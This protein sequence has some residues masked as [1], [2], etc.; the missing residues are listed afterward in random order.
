MA[1]AQSRMTNIVIEAEGLSKRYRLGER[2]RYVALR[3][4]LTESLKAPWRW[5]RSG[6]KGPGADDN[7]IWSLK[8]V[9]FQVRDGEA[10]G[11]VGRNGAGKTTLLKLLARV[12]RPTRGRAA[13]RGRIGSLLEVGT[14]FHPELTGRENVF[15]NGAILGMSRAEIHGKFDEI[16]EFSGVARFLD[17]PLKHY[18]SGMQ[19]RLAFSVA[20]HLEPE[21]LLVDEVLAVGDL[22]FQKKC[23]GKMEEV[24]RHGRTV[25]FVSHSM[26]AI[27]R[28]CTRAIW[29]DGGRVRMMG[30]ADECVDAYGASVEALSEPGAA[31]FAMRGRTD[32][33]GSQ[34]VRFTC[35][36]ICA[37]NGEPR[38]SFE[39]GE[40]LQFELDFE[41]HETAKSCYVG[42]SVL[43]SDGTNLLSSHH[44]DSEEVRALAAGQSYSLRC[45][46]EPNTL[47]P[48]V[49]T[50]QAAI[51]D[52]ATNEFYDWIYSIGT[53]VVTEGTGKYGRTPDHRPGHTQPL[54]QWRWQEASERA[55]PSAAAD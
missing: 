7:F 25:L 34:K 20:A 11:I 14:G 15:L 41:A 44:S 31:V 46:Y 9:T 47:K 27:R 50:L 42:I 6:T 13:V 51:L 45:A 4:V 37:A 26:G 24:A 36:R 30:S 22:E 49:Y 48:G 2:E 5:F 17:T 43:A 39:F 28:L 32:R 18:S 3:D 1:E 35:I 53:F 19:M 33:V 38:G 8:D 10:V 29:L 21:I 23:L 12:T 40:P 16:V 55:H 54:L 52:V